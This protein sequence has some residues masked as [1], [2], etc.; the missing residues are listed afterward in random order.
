[1]SPGSDPSSTNR[2][3][4][5]PA[6]GG[7]GGGGGLYSPWARV[8]RGEPE[9][10]PEAPS[11]PPPPAP[12]S[13]SE[14]PDRSPSPVENAASSS[15]P[16]PS[17]SADHGSNGNAAADA[18]RGKKPAWNMPPNGS[19]EAGPVMGADSWPPL[20][21]STR[22]SPKSSSSD[23]LKALSDGS[24]S[25]PPGSPI[26]S[27]LQKPNSSHPNPNSTSNHAGP[28]RQKS[29]PNPNSMRRGGA[30]GGSSSGSSANGGP[31]PPLP[32]QASPETAQI[33][34]GKP[35]GPEPSPK[36]H[37]NRSNSNWDHGWR[38]SGLTPQSQGAWDHHRG[39][40]SS[41]R[42][43]SGG[44]GSHHG[45]Y[46]SRRDHERGG[47]DWNPPRGFSG[48]DAHM[49]LPP[50]QQ[51]GHPRSFPRP[52]SPASAPFI[53]PLQV[54]PFMS[55]LG[56]AEFPPPMFY[57]G[58]PTPNMFVAHQVPPAVP[59]TM[60]VTAADYQRTALLKQIEYYFS[61][62]NLCK[63]IY[64]RQNMDDQ[65]WVPISLIAGFNRVKQLANNIQ[66]ILDT[67]RGSD[68]VE[69]QGEKIR[70]RND[71]MNWILRAPPNQ[72]STSSGSS[73]PTTPN[74]DSLAARMHNVGLG[75]GAANHDRIWG[76][77]HTE[78][79]LSRSS[80]ENLNN[81][82]QVGEP[83]GEEN[84]HVTGNSESD[85]SLSMRS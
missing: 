27:P 8:V 5:R 71:W 77:T 56:F 83:D 64:L 45:G 22:V 4:P 31:P 46:G 85:R 13:S 55:P 54:R 79:V 43:S 40:G 3:F 81:Q 20:S 21:E 33:I 24:V 67:V 44:G 58:H 32:P 48:R 19:N 73:S 28:V 42:G 38:S 51:R 23:S 25:A 30:G 15:A 14:P 35:S 7:S 17:E 70:R 75:E 9:S 78:V 16:P 34:P 18:P 49:P 66:Y 29:N 26:I 52:P 62:D 39:Y 47:Y 11:S 57:F 10:V 84:V 6:R 1:M 69:V 72:Y 41:R 63:D 80:S 82:S 74:Y 65:G 59:P 76:Q 60:F 12:I 53:S 37:P 36:D 68:I 2:I 50:Q 61:P